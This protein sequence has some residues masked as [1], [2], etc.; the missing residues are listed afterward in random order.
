MHLFVYLNVSLY[1]H[2]TDAYSVRL[3]VV[4]FLINAEQ[5]GYVE[6][7]P[8]CAAWNMLEI[9]SFSKRYLILILIAF[10]SK[11]SQSRPKCRVTNELFIHSSRHSKYVSSQSVHLHCQGWKGSKIS[12]LHWAR[13]KSWWMMFV[14]ITEETTKLVSLVSLG[15]GQQ[16]LGPVVAKLGRCDGIERL[17]STEMH[18]D[19]SNMEENL[20]CHQLRGYL[21]VTVTHDSPHNWVHGSVLQLGPFITRQLEKLVEVFER[22]LVKLRKVRLIDW[23]VRSWRLPSNTWPCKYAAMRLRLMEKLTKNGERSGIPTPHSQV[24]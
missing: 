20:E 23:E 3:F 10:F 18:C 7:L 19:V 5:A 15:D 12:A 13:C 14:Q 2:I 21:V 11:S 6:I 17:G 16:N 24:I 22:S 9:F 8:P 4:N 1:T